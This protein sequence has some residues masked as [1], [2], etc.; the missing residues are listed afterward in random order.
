MTSAF[1]ADGVP[2]A[3]EE[4]LAP[5]RELVGRLAAGDE[6][7]LASLYDRHGKTLYGLAY[8]ILTDRED[9][10]EVVMD[11]FTQAWRGAGSYSAERGSVAAWLVVLVRSRALDRLRSRERRQRALGRAALVDPLA[12][13]PGMGAGPLPSDAGAERGERRERVLAVLASLPESQRRCI[14]LAYYDGLTQTEI[15]ERLAEPLGTVKTRV[16][17]GLMKLRE[18]FETAGAESA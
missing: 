13:S 2:L 18:A 12:P 15:A 4:D 14:E 17:L 11:A 10:E 1:M 16:R 5:D 8:R 7:A 3:A 9:A 6:S